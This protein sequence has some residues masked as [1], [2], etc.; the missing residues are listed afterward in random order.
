MARVCSTKFLTSSVMRWSGLS[1][2]VALELHA[3]MRGVLKPFAEI[4]PSEP[5]PPANLEPLVQVELV[6]GQRD[7]GERER[8]EDPDLFDEGVPVAV[9]ER[10]V[11]PV[12]P[13]VHQHVDRDQCQLHRDHGGEQAAAGPF[14]LRSEIR[15][16]DS[17]DDRE[18][19]ADVLHRAGSPREMCITA[20]SQRLEAM[21]ETGAL[22][23]KSQ[24]LQFALD[25]RSPQP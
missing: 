6:D 9:L 4:M 16:G 11:E 24:D 21:A 12:L 10:A 22:R 17:P 1:G 5:L 2:R 3:V 7:I 20:Q 8:D 13:L 19:G 23:L 25:C 18:R 15:D 14:V